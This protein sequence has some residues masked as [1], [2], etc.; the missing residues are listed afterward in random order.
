VLSTLVNSG[1]FNPAFLVAVIGSLWLVT[2]WSI[3]LRVWLLRI[4][5][6]LLA[7]VSCLAIFFG[8]YRAYAVPRDVMQDI[9]AAQEYL[10]G[11]PIQPPEMNVT[12]RQAIEADGP[13]KSLLWWSDDLARQEVQQRENMLNE[14]WVQ[15]HPPLVTLLTAQVVRFFG[16]IG[17]QA[18]YALLSLLAIGL[19]LGLA[20]W[21]FGLE[22]WQTPGLFAMVA[23]LGWSAVVSNVRLQQLSLPLAGLLA[24]GWVF[25]RRGQS[26]LAGICIGFAVCLKLIPGVLLLPLLARYRSGFV[27]ALLTIL[28]LTGLVLLT[29]PWSD[30][31]QYRATASQVIDQYATYPANQSLLGVFARWMQNLRLPVPYAKLLWLISLGAI[32]VAWAFV[33]F[34]HPKPGETRRA[35]TDAEWSLGLSLIPLLSP[36]AWDHYQVFL[37]LPLIVLAN[38]VRTKPTR[39]TRGLLACLLLMSTIPDST[40]LL[41]EDWLIAHQLRWVSVWLVLPMRTLDNVL[42][43]AWLGYLLWSKTSSVRSLHPAPCELAGPSPRFLFGKSGMKSGQVLLP[44]V[45]IP[46]MTA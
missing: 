30:L 17:T 11:R 15:A 39:F 34:H 10:A 26:R 2:D 8:L 21:K 40:F 43:C 6:I 14:H 24:L 22:D 45:L 36:V 9:V 25:Q 19:I 32:G 37:L 1:L 29:M 12:M 42:I 23:A 5:L 35:V 27:A 41:I 4:G 33:L 13:R 31:A 18:L 38:E 20:Y 46:I 44:A 28:A 16:I 3:P 7:G